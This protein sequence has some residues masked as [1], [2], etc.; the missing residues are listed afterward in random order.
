MAAATTQ[1]SLFTDAN[2][3]GFLKGVAFGSTI[4]PFTHTFAT[5]ELDDINDRVQLVPLRAKGGRNRLYL[6]GLQWA[7]LEGAAGTLRASIVVNQ[8][9]ADTAL[10]SGS[11]IFNTVSTA[12]VIYWILVPTSCMLDDT[13][14]DEIAT[15]D[16]LVTA[17]AGNPIAAALNGVAFYE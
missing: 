8:N 2:A 12:G 6:L 10:L 11:A 3:L 17:A 7:D 9:G 4:I 15:L 5:T 14:N 16:F 1:S 13:D